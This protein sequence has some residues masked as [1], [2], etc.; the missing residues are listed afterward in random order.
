MLADG[1]AYSLM[2][3]LGETYLPAFA[4]ALGLG[5]ATAGLIVTVP[6][7]LGAV[8]QLVAPEI[9]RRVGSLRQMTV[10]CAAIQGLAFVPLVAGALAG[11]MAGWLLFGIASWYWA[12]GLATNAAWNTWVEG[13][14]PGS[15]R[16]RFFASRTRI[17][18]GG[19]LL[20]FVAGGLALQAGSGSAV[21]VL[22]AFAG[23]FAAAGASRLVSSWW[24]AQQSE[25]AGVRD[26]R[27]V[28]W[29]EL[30]RRTRGGDGSLLLYLL[31]VQVAVQISGPYFTPFLLKQLKVSY[32]TFV[33]LVG[34]SF[35]GKILALPL[36][37]RVARQGGARRLLWL[38]GLGIV[39]VAGL[40]LCSTSLAWLLLVQLIG[41][42]VWA[43]YE[44]AMFLMFFENIRLEERTSVLTTYNFGNALAT[45]CGSML[46]G[47]LLLAVGEQRTTYLALFAISTLARVATVVLLA[48]VSS[49]EEAREHLHAQA[50]EHRSGLTAVAP[51]T[52]GPGMLTFVPP[53]A[54]ASVATPA[55]A[56]GELPPVAG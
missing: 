17:T 16:A 44:L 23:V 34:T 33:V 43:A 11:E 31:A 36:W 30:L 32:A 7:L 22:G 2:V 48:R 1:A 8:V 18:Q 12:A 39:P 13:L 3:G 45:F 19:T 53:A 25:A 15:L 35:V 41:G 50:A 4:L 26:H 55:A 5:E 14:V 24:L 56:P 29:R 49:R 28:R 6:M 52:R 21:G 46:G 42:V 9:A 40:W 54:A 38:G 37:G 27:P 47:G 51:T 10:L 20:G